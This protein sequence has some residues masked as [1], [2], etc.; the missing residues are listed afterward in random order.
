MFEFKRKLQFVKRHSVARDYV[1]LAEFLVSDIDERSIEGVFSSFE[2]FLRNY[3]QVKAMLVLSVPMDKAND[4]F[5]NSFRAI[6]NRDKINGL[7]SKALLAEVTAIW[8][9]NDNTLGRTHRFE[10]Q[11]TT[12][13]FFEL[14]EMDGQ[15][16]A[17]LFSTTPSLVLPDDICFYLSKSF[18]KSIMRA[19]DWK[20]MKDE[21]A[22]IH[23]DDVTLLYNQRKLLVDIN[24]LIE[25]YNRYRKGF[26][27][28][29]VDIDHFK[30]VNDN[31]GHLVGTKILKEMSDL[32][33]SK[34]RETDFI[35]RYGGD[36]FV[37]LVPDCNAV[38]G[39]MIGERILRS[40]KNH[41]FDIPEA[42]KINITVSIGVACFPKDAKDWRGI[43]NMADQMMYNAKDQ[44]RS[45]VCLAGELFK[46]V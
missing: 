4:Q 38:M 45:R 25:R 8:Q 26:A 42:G 10:F 2:L 31:H 41:T 34:M 3:Y 14:G 30:D 24:E 5:V 6:Y 33:R 27:V 9:E 13:Y 21:N 16:F 39:Q 12:Y 18:R 19:R 28:L 23:L 22:L 11:S 15:R 43:L 7:F 29:F 36:E 32:F 35:Y 17:C 40:I 20:M 1:S 44:G 37:L 46:E